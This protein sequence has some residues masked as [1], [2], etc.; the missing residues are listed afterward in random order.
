VNDDELRK[1]L[2]R[3]DPVPAETALE[4]P[5]APSARQRLEQIMQNETTPSP[6]RGTLATH[7]R[8]WIL[9]AAAAVVAIVAVG[10]VALN[11]DDSPSTV[12]GPPMELS[13]GAGDS[14]A[15]CIRFDV[16]LLRNMSPAFGGTVTAI[17]GDNVTIAVDHW[18]AGGS[19]DTVL[20]HAQSGMAGLIA[21]FD[22]QVGERYLIT[23][24]DGNVNFCGYSGPADPTLTAAFEE[25]FAG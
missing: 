5:T 17:E 25:A 23:A 4:P 10:V 9:A 6:V 22:F 18:Y 14:M 1:R 3:I 20:L 13:L 11:G 8:S 12:A 19:A 2:Q 16:A 15:S 21:G 7:R 24:A